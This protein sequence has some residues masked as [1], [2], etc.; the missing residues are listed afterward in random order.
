[1]RIWENME[2]VI[3]T[4]K[5][6]IIKKI[7]LASLSSKLRHKFLSNSFYALTSLRIYFEGARAMCA[8]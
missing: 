2:I 4:W 3:I 6:K 8:L 1:M 7:E 5:A